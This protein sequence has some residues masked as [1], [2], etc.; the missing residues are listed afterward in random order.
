MIIKIILLLILILI[1]GVFS[2]TEIAFISINKYK[3]NKEIK[4]KNKKAIKI[5]ELLKDSSTFLSAI[6]I[7][8]TLSGFLASAFAAENFA[9][10]LSTIIKVSF[11]AQ[12]TLTNILVIL[13]TI[14]LS[15][16]TLVLGELVPK[17]IGLAYSDKI[18]FQM[19]EVI[20][21][22][23]KVC[24][25]FIIIL[26][27]STDCLVKLLK[28]KKK[29]SNM[30]EE[31]KSSITDSNLEELEKQLLLNIFEFNDTTIGKIMTPKK[32]V[33]TINITASKEEILKI[34]KEYKYTRFPITD[35]NDIIGVL[36]V[37]DLVI[38]QNKSFALKDYNRRIITLKDS[39]IIDDAYLYL[40]SNYEVMAKVVKNE[41]YIGII[42]LEDII[43]ELIGNIFDEYDQNK[44][45]KQL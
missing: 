1:N 8:I 14:I 35:G 29:T 19:V 6:Q 20:D 26:K 31:I 13:I 36:N 11:L 32:D 27:N 33:I 9:S 42:T 7:A 21:I 30:E 43:E 22:V 2:A 18:A 4:K 40:N 25:P 3:L 39:M 24:K 10:E 17:K 45:T 23:I 38:K 5:A 37:K 34:I 16:F 41:E 15:Y 28:I 44:R 12:E